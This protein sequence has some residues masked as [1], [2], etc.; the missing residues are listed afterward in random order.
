MNSKPTGLLTIFAWCL[1]MGVTAI[2]IGVGAVIPS[3]NLVAK[4]LICPNGEMTNEQQVYTPTP[5]ETV[6]TITWYCID[7]DSGEQKELGIFPMCLYA[8]VFYGLL[9]FAVVYAYMFISARIK[10]ASAA[11]DDIGS[12]KFKAY[13]DDPNERTE[14]IQ[15][16]LEGLEKL[17]KQN[18]ISDEEYKM[19]RTQILEDL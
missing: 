6:T 1:F 16:R 5:V 15:A 10:P 19:K 17:Y 13:N 3:I 9:L 12:T 8:G 14:R 4:P 7:A 18:L 11:D 2:S